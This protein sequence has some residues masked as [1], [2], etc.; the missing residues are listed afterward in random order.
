[1]QP[2]P[3]D[4]GDEY[5]RPPFLTASGDLSHHLESVPPAFIAQSSSRPNALRVSS[6]S[7]WEGVA[8]FSRAY[9][10]GCHVHVSGTTA[11]DRKGFVVGGTDAAAQTSFA[12]DLVETSLAA[13]GA[14]LA[15][16]VRTRLYVRRLGDWEAVARVHGSRFGH[17]SPANTRVQVAHPPAQ[18][19]IPLPYPH[20]IHLHHRRDWSVTST[21]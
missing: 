5:R 3:G 13:L 9:R 16:V 18:T 7:V 21:L 12:L 10:V 11:T 20:L 14:S 19:L 15:D 6:A 8:G 2:L 17:V 1:M 4:C